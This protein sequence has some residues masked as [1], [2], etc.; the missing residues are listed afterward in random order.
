MLEQQQ[1]KKVFTFFTFQDPRFYYGDIWRAIFLFIKE[2]L[3]E[4]SIIGAPHRQL[5]HTSECDPAPS[6]V[7]LLL[8]MR[9]QRDQM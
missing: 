4:P 5:R 6:H 2:E 9:M 1:E 7:I 3:K 8:E